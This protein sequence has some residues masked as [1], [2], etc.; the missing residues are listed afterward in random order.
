[1]QKTLFAQHALLPHGWAD[2]VRVSWNAQ[3]RI[4]QVTTGTQPVAG[5]ESVQHLMPG[6]PNLHS[7]AF[8]RAFSGLTEY[9]S[10]QQD[11]FWSWRKLMYAF[12]ARISPEQLEAVATW[13]Y[14]EMLEAG[15]T[16]VCEFHYVHHQPDGHAYADAATLSQ[17][18]LNAA[19][20]TGI[21]LTLLPVCYQ[22][23]GF[24]G[25]PPNEG[26]KRFINSTPDMLALLAQLQPLCKAQDVRLG[27]A[28]H[29]LRAVTPESLQ[30]LVTG[31]RRM[32]ATAPIHIH[33]AEQVKEVEDCIAW[34][35]QRPV[36]WLMDHIDVNAHWCLVHATH[37]DN[38]EYKQAAASGAVVGICPST[39]ANLGDG[40]F[41][42]PQWRT[43]QGLWGIGSDSHATVSAAEELLLLEYSQRLQLRQRNVGASQAHPEVGTSLYLQAVKG[44]AQASGRAI[45]GIAVGQ[46]ADFVELDPDHVGIAGLPVDK[47]LSGHVLG[48]SRTTAIKRVW[49][50]GQVRVNQTHALHE[51]AQRA[52]ITARA[53]L[54]ET[55]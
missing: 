34:S 19:Q 12:A 11:S 21:G 8:Q 35:G 44:G 42:F 45:A 26:Q 18:L 51:T 38:H 4:E 32:D 36:A 25:L 28:P 43:H 30:E 52:F 9:R 7:H 29:S 2:N 40:I 3:G 13:L 31:L 41:D 55:I 27:V 5:D 16:S 1:M 39:E 49:A 10:S 20:K 17:S 54:L 23:S 33:I 47:V 15:Y 37:M 46:S 14:A 24:G 48:S 53:Q 6:M 50:K 22:S